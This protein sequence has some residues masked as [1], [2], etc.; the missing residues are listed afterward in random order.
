MAKTKSA[1]NVRILHQTGQDALDVKTRLV[2]VLNVLMGIKIIQA[3][4]ARKS[5]LTEGS[6]QVERRIDAWVALDTA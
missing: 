1:K 4:S 2:G 5:A 3:T 6:G